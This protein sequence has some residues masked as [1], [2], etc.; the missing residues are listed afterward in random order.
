MRA[1]MSG[2]QDRGPDDDRGDDQGERETIAC[3]KQLPFQAA[4]GVMT[5]IEEGLPMLQ[6]AKQS[7]QRNRD[8]SEYFAPG[9][10]H[11]IDLRQTRDAK[12]R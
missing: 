1:G 3:M 7:A 6:T 2:H 12:V 8:F 5:Y 11:S 10:C 9:D 4:A